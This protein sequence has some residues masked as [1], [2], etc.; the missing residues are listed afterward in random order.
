M[1]LPPPQP[2]PPPAPTATV[3][4]VFTMLP[5][6]VQPVAMTQ[7]PGDSTRWFAVE[8]SGV[9]RVFANDPNVTAST[10]FLNIAEQVDARFNESGLLGSAFNP[11]WPGTG[12]GDAAERGTGA[13]AGNPHVSRR[14][15]VTSIEDRKRTRMK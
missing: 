3:Q 7:A 8:Q 14:Y 15:R 1:T 11:A 4:Q 6:F 9:I 13:G 10:I 12:E 5:A 2:P